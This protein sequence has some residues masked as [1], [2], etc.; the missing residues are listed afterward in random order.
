MQI[1]E[2]HVQQPCLLASAADRIGRVISDDSWP[3]YTT[4]FC[5]ESDD[6]LAQGIG[7]P[8]LV[9][10]PDP[11]CTQGGDGFG[12][13]KGHRDAPK[14]WDAA[15]A[16]QCLECARDIR[17]HSRRSAAYQQLTDTG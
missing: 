8:L 2:H 6:T 1:N 12:T 17:G 16:G 7:N 5:A 13:A 14:L 9:G 10:L 4:R 11:I 15:L 3:G